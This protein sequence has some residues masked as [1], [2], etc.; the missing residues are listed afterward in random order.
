M[1]KKKEIPRR[2]VWQLVSTG[3]YCACNPG[4]MVP[5]ISTTCWLPDC[6]PL[7]PYGLSPECN[8]ILFTFRFAAASIDLCIVNTEHP[9][10]WNRYIGLV[11]KV[12]HL[13]GTRSWDIEIS[14]TITSIEAC[15]SVR[16]PTIQE[17][18]TFSENDVL[19]S[20]WHRHTRQKNPSAP[21]RSRT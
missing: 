3:L 6:I 17:K 1:A 12:Q 16:D 13:M 9:S 19:I 7:V 18:I 11:R 10:A 5:L 2:V 8:C 20:K 21:Q 14:Y 15:L 4:D